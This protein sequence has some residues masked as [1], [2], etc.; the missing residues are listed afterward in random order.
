VARSAAESS[1]ALGALVLS[2]AAAVVARMPTGRPLCDVLDAAARAHALTWARGAGIRAGEQ[3]A[4]AD[5]PAPEGLIAACDAADAIT[6]ARLVTRAA[7]EAANRA[8]LRLG[9]LAADLTSIIAPGEGDASA[10]GLG[11]TPLDMDGASPEDEAAHREAA[12]WAAEAGRPGHDHGSHAE[13]RE[14]QCRAHAAQ[15]TEQWA[16]ALPLAARRAAEGREALQW[17]DGWSEAT[18]SV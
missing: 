5:A 6:A 2:D 17:W 4:F 16:A 3:P 8:R 14:V 9:A 11:G 18:H 10:P 15:V 12:A 7:G 13:A 1:P